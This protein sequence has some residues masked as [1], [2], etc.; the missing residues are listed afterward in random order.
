LTTLETKSLEGRVAIVTGAAHG[1]GRAT[2]SRLA[3]DGAQIAVFDVDADA[4]REAAS[5]VGGRAYSV[6][7]T[8]EAAVRE[9]VARVEADHGRIDILVNNAGI[10]PYVP[11]EEMTFAEWRRVL[12]TNLDGVF[13][14]CHAVVP[15][16][17][18]GGYGRIV[19][20][21]SDTVLLGLPELTA[22]IASKAGVIGL[23]RALATAVGPHGTT[24]NAIMPGLI[25]TET[26]L[27]S[28]EH[29]FDEV[30]IPG[31]AVK[32]RGQP[33]DVADCVAYLAS[34]AAAFVTGQSI[35][36]NGGQRFN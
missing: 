21:S 11:F 18:A 2:A 29:M 1:I 19:N 8:S 12:S 31:Q 35:A 30:V 36:V 27:G 14:C 28:I 25:A 13:L 32:R 6:D 33:E 24:V 4:G 9:A 22:Y 20:I 15:H 10:Y 16:M 26:V 7:V 34:P 17:R 23:T 5:E 3:H